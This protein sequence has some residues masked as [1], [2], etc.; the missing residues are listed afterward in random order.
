M[1]TK[2]KQ[3]APEKSVKDIIE[4]ESKATEEKYQN[5]ATNANCQ[6]SWVGQ[7]VVQNR[8]KTLQNITAAEEKL[9]G[10]IRKHD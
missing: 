10:S 8:L 6:F 3:E 2:E 7:D 5:I 4:K 9:A 1:K